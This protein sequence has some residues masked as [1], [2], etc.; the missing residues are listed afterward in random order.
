MEDEVE[1]FQAFAGFLKKVPQENL[2]I[3][4]HWKVVMVLCAMHTFLSWCT[5]PLFSNFEPNFLSWGWQHVPSSLGSRTV[6][7]T[8]VQ[9]L[10]PQFKTSE[11]FLS[12]F[13][14]TTL[15][16]WCKITCKAFQN[17]DSF[18]WPSFPK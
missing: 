8:R 6:G 13:G 15:F 11:I 9:L 1:G 18:W 3:F 16:L 10:M 7:V 2:S 14:A 4:F 12:V 17:T 5:Q